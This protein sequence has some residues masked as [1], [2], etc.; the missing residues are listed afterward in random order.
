MTRLI[1]LMKLQ[2]EALMKTARV[3]SNMNR[4]ESDN[5][6]GRAAMKLKEARKALEKLQINS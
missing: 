4:P 3:V 5:N 2:E 1:K 6:F